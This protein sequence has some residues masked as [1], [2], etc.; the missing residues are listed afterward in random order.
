MKLTSLGFVKLSKAELNKE[1][2]MPLN[3]LS[4]PCCCC[5][6]GGPYPPDGAYPPDGSWFFP[7]PPRT[8]P[9]IPD[10]APKPPPPPPPDPWEF[11]PPPKI[12][13]KAPRGLPPG[14]GPWLGS[15]PPL[16]PPP[17]KLNYPLFT[18]F[19]RRKYI[20]HTKIFLPKAPSNEPNIPLV[21]FGSKA[22]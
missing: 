7:P 14:W 6:G 8:P 18:H 5:W 15:P 4:D 21:L 10:R 22:G 20:I 11:E 19:S 9:K 12:L 17:I 2:P 16:L 13:D 3:K 1:A